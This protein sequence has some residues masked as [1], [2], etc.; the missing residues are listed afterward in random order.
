MNP[1]LPEVDEIFL[2]LMIH[3]GVDTSLLSEGLKGRFVSQNYPSNQTIGARLACV[4]PD[5]PQFKGKLSKRNQV[6]FERLYL[7]GHKGRTSYMVSRVS[8][9]VVVLDED[10]GSE[11]AEGTPLGELLGTAAIPSN[12]KIQGRRQLY[13]GE[14][15]ARTYLITDPARLS[16]GESIRV[17]PR[18]AHPNAAIG[19]D[20]LEEFLSATHQ[21]AGDWT[22]TDFGWRKE[23]IRLPDI[24]VVAIEHAQ[25]HTPGVDHPLEVLSMSAPYD[26]EKVQ[27]VGPAPMTYFDRPTRTWRVPMSAPA[28]LIG[29][30]LRI[31]SLVI[32][33]DGT[34]LRSR[35]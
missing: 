8:D 6:W 7:D 2:S 23:G 27:M 12:I 20:D 33:P 24:E 30:I 3:H 13:T 32:L 18:S 9:T 11:I 4:P 28:E 29:E 16:I 19:N 1:S 25:Q 21:K 31:W 15:E 35:I 17:P 10:Y 5:A 34:I 14:Y 26:P 22:R